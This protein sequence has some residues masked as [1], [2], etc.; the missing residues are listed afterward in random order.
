MSAHY[1]FLLICDLKSDTPK[2]VIEGLRFMMNPEYEMK[3]PPTD[4]HFLREIWK[5]LLE[6]NN[7]WVNRIPGDGFVSLRLVPDYDAENA[8]KL[9]YTFTFRNQIHGDGLSEY[10]NIAEWLRQ[11]S[12]TRG[13]VGYFRSQYSEYPYLMYFWNDKVDIVDTNPGHRNKTQ[14]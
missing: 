13:Y 11:Y 8:D 10:V 1:D 7:E 9:R 2:Q 6:I 4:E 12:E 14:N 5:G 3:S